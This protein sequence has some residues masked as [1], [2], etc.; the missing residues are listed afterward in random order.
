MLNDKIKCNYTWLG[1]S[2]YQKLF[3]NVLCK[4]DFSFTDLFNN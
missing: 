1:R 3:C 2:I 4:S